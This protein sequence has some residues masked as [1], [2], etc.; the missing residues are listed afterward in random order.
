MRVHCAAMGHPIVGDPA[1]GIYG[2]ASANG[3]FAEETMNQIAPHRASIVLQKQIN[4]A[5]GKKQM[6]LHAHELSLRHPITDED[7]TWEAPLP[8]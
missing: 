2:E 4:E 1:Y 7:M 8:F 6:C 3:G 5:H